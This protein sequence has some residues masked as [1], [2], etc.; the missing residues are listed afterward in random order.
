M[1][2]ERFNELINLF[3]DKAIDDVG[4]R[5]LRQA[6]DADPELKEAFIRRY[7][8]HRALTASLSLKT[9]KSHPQP[10][11][12]LLSFAAAG[13]AVLAFAVVSLLVGLSYVF[14]SH[15]N[16]TATL[17]KDNPSF[18]IYQP[19]SRNVN[20]RRIDSA[21]AR[22]AS[23]MAVLLDDKSLTP[24]AAVRS[25]VKV[26]QVIRLG[27]SPADLLSSQQQWPSPT[28]R[29][30]DSDNSFSQTAGFGSFQTVLP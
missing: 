6:I 5:E 11:L 19:S 3:L 1:S 16:K 22:F 10:A 9:E 15:Q 21:R 25:L 2:E 12:G 18:V 7:Q 17:S 13:S 23:E 8:L 26:N 14:E 30:N 28:F 24:P 27:D 29:H 20:I 4:V